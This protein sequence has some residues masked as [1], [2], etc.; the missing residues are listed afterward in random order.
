MFISEITG[1]QFRCLSRLL[2]NR[3]LGA[4]V[5][6]QEVFHYIRAHELPS[7]ARIRTRAT[8]GSPDEEHVQQTVPTNCEGLLMETKISLIL[9]GLK[10]PSD[11]RLSRKKDWFR[12]FRVPIHI[13]TIGLE[14]KHE[15]FGGI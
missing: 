15:F 5:Y 4:R 2:E 7:K 3:E 14:E 8:L 9:F 11:S 13:N 6:A 10:R 1:Q 12:Y